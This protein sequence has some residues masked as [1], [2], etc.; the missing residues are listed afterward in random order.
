[1][2]TLPIPNY[3]GLY[4]ITEYGD[5]Y[6][7]D[8]TVIGKDGASYSFKGRKLASRVNPVTGYIEFS[9]WKNNKGYTCTGHVLVANTFITNPD[10]LPVVNHLDG[11][12]QNNHKSNLERCTHRHNLIHAIN[13]GLRTYINRLTKDEFM[14]CLETV[15][16]GESYAELA[17][18]VPYQVPFLSTKLRKLAK[19][20]GL[21]NELNNSLKLQRANR[22][23]QVCLSQREAI[24]QYTLD[25]TFVA[26]HI[27]LTAATKAL[28]KRS[29]GTISNALNP[30]H[31]QKTAYGYLWER[32]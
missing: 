4:E 13:T 5:V 23:R 16:A 1:M 28:G 18:R 12:K 2:E 29:S 11:N 31:P 27:S 9:L 32:L 10:N 8:R 30:N 21:E 14:D 25:G 6:S 26:T 3:E 19:E 24:A 15:I 17:K 22:N 20:N 7:L